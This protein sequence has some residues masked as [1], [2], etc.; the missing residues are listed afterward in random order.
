[1]SDTAR[2][3]NGTLVHL[4]E[5]SRDEYNGWKNKETWATALHLSNDEGLYNMCL[6]LV[7]GKKRWPAGDAIEE[8]VTE[9]VERVLYPSD[10]VEDDPNY[11]EWI[12][13]MIADVGSWWRVDWAD[14]ADSFLEE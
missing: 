7:E 8:W 3:E 1:M 10:G 12:R 11:T 9:Q 5:G 14:V 2:T 13:L 4:Y 6:E